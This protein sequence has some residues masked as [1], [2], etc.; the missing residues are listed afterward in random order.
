MTDPRLSM[1]RRFQCRRLYRHRPKALRRRLERIDIAV[2]AL[3][4]RHAQ[5]QRL[6]QFLPILEVR[7]GNDDIGGLRK[8]R[9][10]DFSGDRN[11]IEQPRSI[12]SASRPLMSSRNVNDS[13]N[14][15]SILNS[16][17]AIGLI[18]LK[19]ASTLASARKSDG[20]A[21]RRS[22]SNARALGCLRTD[23]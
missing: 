3:R 21:Y 6:T 11:R 14:Y 5:R 4:V 7:I 20:C 12:S 10:C 1:R 22:V 23:A 15:K 2:D 19:G 9:R 18:G 16:W 13:L 17:S 8:G